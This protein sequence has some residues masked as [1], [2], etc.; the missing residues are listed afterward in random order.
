MG[1]CTERWR[2]FIELPNDPKR[3]NIT[4]CIG[5]NVLLDV[6]HENNNWDAHATQ[7]SIGRNLLASCHRHKPQVRCL[8]C[9]Q[10]ISPLRHA[11]HATHVTPR[12]VRFLGGVFSDLL[13]NLTKIYEIL[14]NFVN[15][16]WIGCIFH[17]ETVLWYITD[18]EYGISHMEYGNTQYHIGDMAY[19]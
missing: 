5:N 12:Y 11:R 14:W 18:L 19:T 8:Y 10:P 4:F 17:L 16:C 13:L 1:H 15:R 7:G 2:H 9:I 6:M 3:V